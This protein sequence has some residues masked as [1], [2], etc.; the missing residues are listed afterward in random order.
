VIPFVQVLGGA[1]R[2]NANTSSISAGENS[3]VVF[4]GGGVDLNLTRGLAIRAA[5][6]DYMWTRFTLNSGATGTQNTL[7]V[8]CGVVFRFGERER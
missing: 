2:L 1:A 8:S 5:Q 3:P 6:V 4:A 7:R